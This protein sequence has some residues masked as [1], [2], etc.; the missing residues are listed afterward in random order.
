MNGGFGGWVSSFMNVC[1]GG[2]FAN[3]PARQKKTIDETL[4]L[5]IIVIEPSQYMPSQINI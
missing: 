2:G 4:R 3:A 5:H 1:Y